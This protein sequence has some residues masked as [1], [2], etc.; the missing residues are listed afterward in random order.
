ML[1]RSESEVRGLSLSLYAVV[2]KLDMML[3]VVLSVSGCIIEFLVYPAG[4]PVS[5][6]CSERSTYIGMSW[7][8]QSHVHRL[9]TTAY[10]ERDRPRTNADYNT[11]WAMSIAYRLS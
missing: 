1:F 6:A 7:P 11:E 5:L 10:S 3:D 4:H 2:G 8:T 9:P